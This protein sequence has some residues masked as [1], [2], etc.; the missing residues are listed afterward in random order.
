MTREMLN[1]QFN[2]GFLILIL[3]IYSQSANFSALIQRK[4]KTPW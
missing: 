1:I 4:E 3:N 2:R